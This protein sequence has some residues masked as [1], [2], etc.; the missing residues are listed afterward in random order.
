LTP[1]TDMHIEEGDWR[2]LRVRCR[3]S[4]DNDNRWVAQW[5]WTEIIRGLSVTDDDNV[6]AYTR[7]C[8]WNAAVSLRLYRRRLLLLGIC[9]SWLKHRRTMARPE[10]GVP[11]P[12]RAEWRRVQC[13]VNHNVGQVVLDRPVYAAETRRPSASHQFYLRPL[14]FLFVCWSC[15]RSA[16]SGRSVRRK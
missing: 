10:L 15:I 7:L 1:K 2:L 12:E 5:V 13:P 9:L 3:R 8:R 4:S 11:R 14:L 6:T 16:G